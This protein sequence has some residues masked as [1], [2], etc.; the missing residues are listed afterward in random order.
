MIEADVDGPNALPLQLDLE[1]PNLKRFSATRRVAR[2]I[3]MG[4]A[5][6][7]DQTNRGIDDQLDQA[8]LRAAGR[9]AGDL[10][11]RAAAARDAGDLPGRGPRPVLVLRSAQTIGRTAEGRAESRFL[12]E[13][14]DEE[15]RRRLLAIRE[16]RRLRR[17]ALGAARAG[18]GA[19]RG[20]GAARRPWAGSP[21]RLRDGGHG[22]A[23]DGRRDPRRARRRAAHVPQHARVRRARQGAARGAPRRR[24]L[25]TS[26]GS[27]CIDEREELNLD[28]HE[29]RQAETQTHALR[30]GGDAADRRD[31]R[32]DADP[33]PGAGKSEVTWEQTRVSGSEPIPVRV[34]K[35]LEVEEGLITEYSGAR[36]RMDLDRVPL[37]KGDHVGVKELWSYYAQYLYLPRLRDSK[38]L[39]EAIQNG[40][41]R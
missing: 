41:A 24:A 8:R 28:A 27:R 14:A 21:A 19:G 16:T 6:T 32:L 29:R 30:R 39:A 1:N 7:L 9:V 10:R 40:V 12:D 31:V 38:S 4:S 37:W 13:H 11:R 36:L 23:G 2:T 22:R 15:I 18:G 17:R 20:R 35:K 26:P 3:Y 33:A 5:P 25:R 34:S